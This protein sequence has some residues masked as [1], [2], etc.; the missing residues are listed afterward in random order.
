M[1]SHWYKDAILYNVDVRAF[2]DSNG[3]GIGD[4]TGLIDKLHYLRELGVTA[5]V[6][7]P[8]QHCWLGKDGSA[9]SPSKPVAQDFER[10]VREAHSRRM[11]V[12]TELLVDQTSDQALDADLLPA[13]AAFEKA[14]RHW[15]DAGVD[16]V[17]IDVAPTLAKLQRAGSVKLPGAHAIVK[18]TRALIDNHYAERVIVVEANRSPDD[19]A[20]YFGRGDQGHMAFDV[21]FMPRLL[22]AVKQ[23]SRTLLVQALRRTTDIPA[24]CQWAVFLRHHKELSLESCTDSERDEMYETYAPEPRMRFKTGI[25]R[26]LAPLFENDR[27]RIELAYALMFSLQGSPV[28]YYGDEIG[29]GDNVYLDDCNGLRTPMQWSS[30][31]NAG[32]SLADPARLTVPANAG[33]IYGYQV[34]NVEAQKRQ[35]FSLFNWMRRLI[36]VRRHHAVFGHG[37]IDFLEPRNETILAYVRRH[38]EERILVVANLSGKAQIVDLALGVYAGAQPLELLGG[39]RF[40]RIGAGPYSVTLG[41]YGCFWLLLSRRVI[42]PSPSS[43]VAAGVLGTQPEETE[44]P[45]ALAENSPGGEL[46]KRTE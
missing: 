30:D 4:L 46:C 10:F 26:R 40:R 36:A 8:R 34:V 22:M 11:H 33:P 17:K 27:R 19:V 29:M 3:D 13:R 14:I 45:A 23:E 28:I 44:A 37:T 9:A 32:F 25:R 12:I 21:S 16:G 39:T 43:D 42:R 20:E 41:P 1:D 15:L 35:P 5:L 18:E 38:R 24:S 2:Y 7:G 31:R 6:L